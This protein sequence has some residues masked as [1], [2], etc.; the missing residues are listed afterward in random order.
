MTTCWNNLSCNASH[1]PVVCWAGQA[2]LLAVHDHQ[3]MAVPESLTWN[4]P[5]GVRKRSPPPTMPLSRK[6]ERVMAIAC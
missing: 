2:Q 4:G 3:L 1:S 5:A 6:A